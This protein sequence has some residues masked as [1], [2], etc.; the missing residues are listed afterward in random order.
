ME[1]RIT[2]KWQAL[3]C[4][5]AAILLA[6]PLM[7][8]TADSSKSAI[9]P[10]IGIE[11]G[12]NW[13]APQ[14]YRF[15]GR[16]IDRLN[17]DRSW[18]AGVVGGYSFA[19]GFRPEIE[20]DARRNGLTHD[21]LGRDS[22]A[23]NAYAAM[24]NLWY[25]FRFPRGLFSVLH[26]YFGGGVG[27]VRSW[28]SSSP[29]LGGIPIARDPSTEFA[30]QFG[31]GIGYDISRN[32][33]ISVDY[34][35]LW[36][37]KGTF[38]DTF[39][40]ALPVNDGIK[41]HYGANTAMLSLRYV[42][43]GSPRPVVVQQPSPPV[44]PPPPPAPPAVAPSPPPPP[45]AAAPPACNPPAG[46]QVDANCH[47]IEQTIVLRAIDF[48]FNSVHLTAPAQRTLDDVAD[49]LLKQPELMV[50]IQGY[51]DS[52]GSAD[53]NQHL[54]Q[55]RADAVKSYLVSRGVNADSLTARGFGEA[56]PIATNATAEGRAQNRRVAFVVTAAPAHVQVKSPPA[57]PA[58]TQA[59]KQGGEQPGN[60]PKQ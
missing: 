22:G 19:S 45:V 2:L 31:A 41:Q 37:D 8:Q 52:R 13:E 24:A 48:Q 34:R 51:A 12:V 49:G 42:F 27:E 30:Y 1:N 57:T 59:A 43:G 32:L 50:E 58:S 5:V 26:P 39:G 9:G 60:V 17:F 11:G 25:Q 10:Y 18:A 21:E 29:E 4:T 6:S 33:T 55:L 53:Y 28:Y 16:V 38:H 40:P 35:R 15:E 3:S 46:F 47:I 36:S 54:S 7:A 44:A 56:D 23:D 14:D 20:L